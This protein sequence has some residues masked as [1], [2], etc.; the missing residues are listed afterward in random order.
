MPEDEQ[1]GLLENHG[2]Q[3]VGWTERVQMIYAGAVQVEKGILFST[4]ITL[5]AFVPLFTTQGVEGQI[6]N[7]MARTHGYALVGALIATFSV[8]PVLASYLLPMHM[9]ETETIVVRALRAVYEPVLRWALSRRAIMV[10]IGVGFLVGAKA[11]A[12]TTLLM[13]MK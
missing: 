9:G 7:P 10:L 5:A 11:S 12:A 2:T 6:F 4:A 3:R 13:T 8:T 1:R